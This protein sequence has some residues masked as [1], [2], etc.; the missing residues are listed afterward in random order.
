MHDEGFAVVWPNG[1]NE[2]VAKSILEVRKKRRGGEST[3]E[4]PRKIVRT[5]CLQVFAIDSDVSDTEVCAEN[6]PHSST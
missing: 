3:E 1:I 2:L 5:T 6:E 4:R